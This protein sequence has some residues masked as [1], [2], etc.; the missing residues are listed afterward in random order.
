[1]EFLDLDK[2]IEEL[3]EV[4]KKGYGKKKVIFDNCYSVSMAEYNEKDDNVS[5]Y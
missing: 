4:Q 2:F 1:M 3:Q 5:I